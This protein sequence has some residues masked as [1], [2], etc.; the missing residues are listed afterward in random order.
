M[1]ATGS[2]RGAGGAVFGAL[3]HVAQG[4]RRDFA[5]VQGIRAERY[6]IQVEHEVSARAKQTLERLSEGPDERMERERVRRA[7][8]SSPAGSA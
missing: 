8:H 1:L 2:L 7:C 5:S 4:G 6:A 3:G